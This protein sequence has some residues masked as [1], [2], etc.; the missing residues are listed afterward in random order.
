[1]ILIEN[2]LKESQDVERKRKSSEWLKNTGS[3]S[4]NL[5]NLKAQ[6]LK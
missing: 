6:E 5:N 1:M 4:Q 2:E 3:N